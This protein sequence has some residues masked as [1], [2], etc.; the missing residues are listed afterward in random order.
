MFLHLLNDDQKRAC[1]SLVGAMVTRDGMV[2]SAETGYLKQLMI[3]S[4]LGRSLG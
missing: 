1:M 4:G 2:D 3:E